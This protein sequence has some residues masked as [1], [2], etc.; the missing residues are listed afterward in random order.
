MYEDWNGKNGRNKISITF[1][2][3]ISY[4]LEQACILF[5]NHFV[6]QRKIGKYESSLYYIPCI[7]LNFV[8][9][10]FIE[11]VIFPSAQSYKHN[12]CIVEKLHLLDFYILSF[13]SIYSFWTH[14]VH[15]RNTSWEI[16]LCHKL[17]DITI[18][19]KRKWNIRSSLSHKKQ[20]ANFVYL[21]SQTKGILHRI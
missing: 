13:C 18:F 10:I 8:H 19:T 14:V 5:S 20:V 11:I 12:R 16:W 7:I 2:R 21:C 4:M 15:L 9:R 17:Q 1:K 6:T 3:V